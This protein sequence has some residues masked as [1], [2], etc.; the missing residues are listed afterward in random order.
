[1]SMSDLAPQLA[2]SALETHYVLVMMKI[3][4]AQKEADAH[5]KSRRLYFTV[6]GAK[7]NLKMK[8]RPIFKAI[9]LNIWQ[10]Q[11]HLPPSL[12]VCS[13]TSAVPFLSKEFMGQCPILPSQSCIE[14]LIK[15]K[16]Q[17]KHTIG[18]PTSPHKNRQVLN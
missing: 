16:A 10:K 3:W 8:F 17:Q 14:V 2:A 6:R 12:A 11:C 13:R 5:L 15:L 7:W 18:I 9:L 4:V 1:M